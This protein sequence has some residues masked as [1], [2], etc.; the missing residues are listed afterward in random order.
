MD[1]APSGIWAGLVDGSYTGMPEVAAPWEATFTPPSELGDIGH[2]HGTE[3]SDGQ[4]LADVH[5]HDAT[6]ALTSA[7][8][9]AG[10]TYTPTDATSGTF[11]GVGTGTW[12]E[13]PAP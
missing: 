3:W 6:E 11:E 13:P 4:W 7:T 2:L 10:G 8:G 12:S 9:Q 5:I 1:S